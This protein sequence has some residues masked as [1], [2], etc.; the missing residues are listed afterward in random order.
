M[1]EESHLSW[2]DPDTDRPVSYDDLL[3]QFCQNYNVDES[4]VEEEL[5]KL[6]REYYPLGKYNMLMIANISK[7]TW[8]DALPVRIG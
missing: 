4:E 8:Q 7:S 1:T 3:R 5:E 6:A 2:V